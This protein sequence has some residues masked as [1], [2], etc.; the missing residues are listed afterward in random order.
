MNAVFEKYL[1]TVDTCRKPLPASERIDIERRLKV[2]F[3]KWN[4]R[5]FRK[6][7]F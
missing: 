7:G 3:W 1:D 4:G 6:N 2:P 5:I